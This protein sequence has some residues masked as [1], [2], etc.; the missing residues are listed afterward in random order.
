MRARLTDIGAANFGYRSDR[1]APLERGLQNS[2]MPRAARDVDEHNGSL[3]HG[4]STVSQARDLNSLSYSKPTHVLCIIVLKF[5]HGSWRMSEE[6]MQ[7]T[8]DLAHHLD[9]V[10][11]SLSELFQ[12][13]I[14]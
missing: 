11:M 1:H 6:L 7:I 13:L 14:A 8:Q 2:E 5:Q 10:A 9:E 4:F 3:S 12:A